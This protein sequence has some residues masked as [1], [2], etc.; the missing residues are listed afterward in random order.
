[1]KSHLKNIE[2]SEVNQNIMKQAV[3]KKLRNGKIIVQ[4]QIKPELLKHIGEAGEKMLTDSLNGT[5]K[6]GT[7]H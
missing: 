5:Q 6:V 4:N 3:L 1:M 2:E 7:R